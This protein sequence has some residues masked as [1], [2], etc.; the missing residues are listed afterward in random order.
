[1]AINNAP[2][3]PEIYAATEILEWIQRNKKIAIQNY[4]ILMESADIYERALAKSAPFESQV[5]KKKAKRTANCCRAAAEDC[6]AAA[7]NFTKMNKIFLAEY[8]ELMKPKRKKDG[9]VNWQS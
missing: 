2:E 1:M 9:Y 3:V 4:Q 8:E 6:K 7:I 5:S